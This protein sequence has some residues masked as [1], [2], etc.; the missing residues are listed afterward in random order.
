MKKILV[1]GAS[2]QLGNELKFLSNKLNSVQFIY[3]D[4][5]ELDIT[6][7]NAIAIFIAENSPTFV[8][9]CAAY[10]AVDKAE[11][12]Q[13]KAELLNASAVRNLT[14][15][16][17]QNNSYFIHISTDYVFSGC[18]YRPYNEDDTTSP[19][20]TY[21]RTK[22]QGE[23]HALTYDK[24]IVIRTAWLYSCYGNNF[25]KTM[26]KLGSQRNELNVVFDQIGTPTYAADLAS[27]ILQIIEKIL[28]D[29]TT[30]KRGIYHYSNEGVCSWY[31]F[32]RKIIQIGNY[33]CTVRPIEAKDYPT[34]AKRPYYSVLSKKKIKDV[35]SITI[36][37]W[38]DSLISCMK[39]LMNE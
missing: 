35:Y 14:E 11:S 1:T 37:H 2:G 3:T 9:N 10:T 27:A 4:Y 29:P 38:E 5:E 36:P 7:A 6:N 20:S 30:F 28:V 15:A 23:K 13:Q 17:R 25:V 26:F 34:P 31:D 33:T 18:S 22:L 12:E 24:S 39:I 32:A 8:I 16:C 21:G 19:T